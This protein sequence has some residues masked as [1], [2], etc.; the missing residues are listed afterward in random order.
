M[1]STDRIHRS[2]VA[3]SVDIRKVVLGIPNII[4]KICNNVIAQIGRNTFLIILLFL[5]IK[6]I[7]LIHPFSFAFQ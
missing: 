6:Q 3:G 1:G 2:P 7:E 5:F 4:I